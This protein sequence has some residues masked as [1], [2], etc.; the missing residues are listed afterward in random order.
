MSIRHLEY[1]SSNELLNYPF[2]DDAK[3][4][5][6]SLQVPSNLLIDTVIYGKGTDRFFIKQISQDGVNLTLDIYKYPSTFIFTVTVGPLQA[7]VR[8]PIVVNSIVGE[9]PYIGKFLFGAGLV[10]MTLPATP[11]IF[12]I[13]QTEFLPSV[14]IPAG[15]VTHSVGID[16]NI[17]AVLLNHVKIYPGCNI[18]AKYKNGTIQL[19]TGKNELE[20]C[21]CEEI[22]QWQKYIVT[23]NGTLA[24]EDS[25]NF[26]IEGKD[27]V[28]VYS[29]PDSHMLV[30]T[31]ECRPCCEDCD[32]QLDDFTAELLAMDT[33][34]TDLDD[35]ITDLEP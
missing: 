23:I 14:V 8:K 9:Y 2:T 12:T 6:L 28:N 21:E 27:C 20:A 30:I 35:R 13:D 26:K 29:E 24:D 34:R 1:L 31:D 7:N 18:I 11:E 4:D 5:N 25:A 10:G 32:G 17:L 3:L 15:M 22:I 33:E 16:D 19:L